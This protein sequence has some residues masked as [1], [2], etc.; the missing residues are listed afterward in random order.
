MRTDLCKVHPFFT[1]ATPSKKAA[2]FFTPRGFP[3]LNFIPLLAD[4]DISASAKGVSMRY[5]NADAQC[6]HFKK[7]Y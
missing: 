2:A 1:S 3:D 6:K 7:V 5:I 4:T